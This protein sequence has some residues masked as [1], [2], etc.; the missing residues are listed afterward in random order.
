MYITVKGII[1]YLIHKESRD[2]AIRLFHM[3]MDAGGVLLDSNLES[4]I[5]D[6]ILG[7]ETVD[8]M[9]DVHLRLLVK[10]AWIVSD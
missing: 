9:V 2:E 6:A 1:A 3:H 4:Q 8:K 7:M 5:V 10:T